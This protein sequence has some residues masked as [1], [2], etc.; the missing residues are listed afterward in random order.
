MKPHLHFMGIGGVMMS[1]LAKW[2]AQE[3]YPVSG[4]DSS[5]SS[6]LATLR[7]LGIDTRIGHDPSHLQGADVLVHTAAVAEHEAELATAR[8]RGLKVLRRIELLGEL[9]RQRSCVTVT[10]THGKSTTTG[11]IA[12]V[13]METGRDPSVLIGAHLPS[14]GSNVRYGQGPHLIAEVDE[15]D[16]GFAKL[17]SELA[18]ITN[19]EDDHIAGGF[20]ERRTYHA[21][22][23]DL[24]AAICK[25]A[26]GAT[27]VL[28]CADWPELTALL[29][30]HP[31]RVSYG[32]A[33]TAAYRAEVTALGAH[34][35]RFVLHTPEGATQAV[36]LCVPGEHNIQNATAA[37]AAAH[38]SGIEL[39]TAAEG[40]AR[41][42]GIGRRWQRHGS[43]NGALV[44]DDYAHHPTEVK[45]TLRAARHTG[46]RVR[47]VLQ[48][49][50]WVRTAQLWPELADAAGLAD[51]V[52]VL[53]IYSAGEQAIPGISSELIVDRL[54][55]QGK[56]SSLHDLSSAQRY[57][58][59]SLQKN[60]LVI[61]LGAGDVWKVAA[62]LVTA[63]GGD[64]GTA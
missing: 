18:V 48:P 60:D 39:H 15:S 1:G 35:S 57:L 64:D 4:C 23:A 56:P 2:Y 43:I 46:R 9:L 42:R 5:E 26:S 62:G 52:L 22:R 47:A 7:A 38:L 28:H 16:T 53:G 33:E 29:V 31:N 19:L 20:S 8:A 41:Y 40:L 44:I 45:A 34:G 50:R 14:L 37:L 24:D 27:T 25:F 59:D 51:E 6:E 58:A 17:T 30:D 3:G 36:T 21:S 61:T 12:T 55:R 54:H 32:L 10:G 63:C 11:M 49:H 13:F